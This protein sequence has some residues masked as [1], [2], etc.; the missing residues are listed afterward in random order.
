MIILGMMAIFLSACKKDKDKPEDDSYVISCDLAISFVNA[1]GDD[2]LDSSLAG[3]Y[4]FEKM[5]L[6][7]LINDSIVEVYDTNM[8]VPRNMALI[9]ETAP[10]QLTV[11]T[12][13][14]PEGQPAPG[15]IR[16]GTAIAYLQLDNLDTDTITTEWEQGTNHFYNT[17]V[18]YN[19]VEQP[20]HSPF[21]VM[22]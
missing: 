11:L 20:V 17:K 15:E 13:S 5:R 19:G 16:T 1:N 14:E 18:W 4:S 7:Y 6:Y 12:F 9:T 22:K 2:L 10:V 21:E 3:S 8:D